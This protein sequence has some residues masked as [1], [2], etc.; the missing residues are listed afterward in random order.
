MFFV[1]GDKVEEK[2]QEIPENLPGVPGTMCLH[3][4]IADDIDVIRY[5]ELS[6]YCRWPVMCDCGDVKRHAFAQEM[7]NNNTAPSPSLNNDVF[8][9]DLVGK[10]VVVDYQNTPYPGIVVDIDVELD[11]ISVKV[12]KISGINRY[13]WPA[14]DDI[15]WYERKSLFGVCTEPPSK[16]TRF[17]KLCDHDYEQL[18]EANN[19]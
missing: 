8:S 19:F 17:F 12:M 5:R 3:Q 4:V 2:D 9:A 18:V 6:C 10:W 13:S 14:K 7:N 16:V 1:S 11:E 15:C